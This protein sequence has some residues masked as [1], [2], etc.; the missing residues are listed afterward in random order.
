M[1]AGSMKFGK[2]SVLA[3]TKPDIQSILLGAGLGDSIISFLASSRQVPISGIQ[4]K[5]QKGMPKPPIKSLFQFQPIYG[6]I[7]ILLLWVE[8]MIAL[9]VHDQI[10]RPHIGD[11]LVVMMLYSFV[12]AF[13][14]ASVWKTALAVLLFSYLVEISQYF[15]LVNR[16]GL[17]NS[18]LANILLGNTFEWLDL[19]AYTAG[20]AL[21]IGLETLRNDRKQ[22]FNKS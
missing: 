8:I 7:S 10:I 14:K 12:R 18:R 1:T 16:L 13:L 4:F 2:S 11:F 20:I 5:I 9:Y 19:L 6:I 22:K 17:Q 21:V 3:P 15:H